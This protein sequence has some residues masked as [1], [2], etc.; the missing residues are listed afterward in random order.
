M[1]TL[2]LAVFDM[3][4]TTIN[5]RDEVYRVL[6]AVVERE[7]AQFTDEQFQQWMG[8]EKRWAITNLLA[9]GGVEADEARIDAVFANFLAELSDSYTAQPP[10]P[11]AGVVDA[12]AALRARGVK[13]GLT[14][15]FSREIAELILT[16]MDWQIGEDLAS[17]TIDVL[18]CAD[19]VPAGRPAPDMIQQVMARLGV[20]DPAA[21]I[22][23]GDTE[24]D[25]RSA[26][27]AGV[28]SVGV[29]TG[30]LSREQ[31]AALD[32]DY[33]FDSAADVATLS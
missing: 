25:V 16:A 19:E 27:A 12:L 17:T 10:E 6:R 31:F 14:T 23:S 3:A 15:G 24:V 28:R 30:H 8:T 2:Q 20:S 18:V 26:Q 32:A 22:S 1:T 11:I 5:D 29:L 13:V 33:I 4:G 7:G 9:L 21:V